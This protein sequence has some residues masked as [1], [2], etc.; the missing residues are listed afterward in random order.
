MTGCILIE[1]NYFFRMNKHLLSISVACLSLCST[2]SFTSCNST[3]SG[4]AVGGGLGAGAGAIIGNNVDGLSTGEG[5][6]IGGVLGAVAGG[7]NG[8][9]NQRLNEAERNANT[10]IINV[11]N[12]NGSFT[13]V[14]LRRQGNQWVGPRN[15]RYNN[16]PTEGQLSQSYGF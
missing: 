1:L 6:L 4:A 16:L 13:P 15:E 14:E 9:Q 7:V 11:Q 8:R 5:A 10:Q 12:S 2:L 3:A